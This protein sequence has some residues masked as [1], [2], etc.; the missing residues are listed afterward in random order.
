[1]TERDVNWETLGFLKRCIKHYEDARKK[2]ADKDFDIKLVSDEF[3][4]NL[5]DIISDDEHNAIVEIID[6]LIYAEIARNKLSAHQIEKRLR[7]EG[8][9]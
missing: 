1:M 6:S 3:E 8:N 2:I 4:L 5:S 9:E 7:G